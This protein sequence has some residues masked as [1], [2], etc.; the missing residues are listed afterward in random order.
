MRVFNPRTGKSFFQKT[1]RR[2]DEAG[3]AR[4]LIFSCYRRYPFLSRHRTRLW[5][6]EA[7]ES[8]RE[9]WSFDLWAYVRD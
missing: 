6:L 7:L 1:R 2:F 3:H 5:F 8:A 9:E 4:E